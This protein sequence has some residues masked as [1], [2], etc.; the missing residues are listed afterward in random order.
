MSGATENVSD[1]SR[2]EK[3]QAS[4]KKAVEVA[5]H[6]RNMK[7]S[8]TR[9]VEDM[10]RRDPAKYERSQRIG[11]DMMTRNYEL[12][13]GVDIDGEKLI[14]RRLLEAL[15]SGLTTDDFTEDEISL[16]EKHRQN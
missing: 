2:L 15:D 10:K 8:M 9:A 5:R 6:E 11:E 16:L 1:M 13:V 7:D 3:M 4:T 14:V 12:K